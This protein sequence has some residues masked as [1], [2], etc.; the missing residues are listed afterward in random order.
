MQT[1]EFDVL[2]V[3]HVPRLG[4]VVLQSDLTVEDELRYYYEGLQLSLLASRIPFAAAVT[5]ESLKTMEAHL[6]QSM[7]LFPPEAEFDCVGYGCTSASLHIGSEQVSALCRSARPCAQA[8]NPM[9]AA[10]AAMQHT[11]SK[12]IGFIAP[13]TPDVSQS[14]VDELEMHG[15]KVLVAATFNEPEDRIVGRITPESIEAACKEIVKQDALD[16]IFVA[17]TSMKC[18]RVIPKI[19]SETGVVMM[20]SNQVLAWDMA[21]L[22]GVAGEI[23]NKGKLFEA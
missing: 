21:R 19:E 22:S 12:R 10:L 6:L 7:S 8:T 23:L 1:L 18:A 17:C 2:P 9:Q 3:N 4:L 13:Y 5:V 15:I 20:S 11:Q 14:M 16:A